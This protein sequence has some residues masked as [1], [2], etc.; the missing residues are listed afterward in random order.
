[1]AIV[2][3]SRCSFSLSFFRRLSSFYFLFRIAGIRGPSPFGTEM[4]D[5]RMPIPVASALMPMRSKVLNRI[6]SK[7]ESI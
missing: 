2:G 7:I 4:S 6:S 1:M 5:A 3:I